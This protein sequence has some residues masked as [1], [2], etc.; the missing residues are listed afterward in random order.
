MSRNDRSFS[1]YLRLIE[2]GSEFLEKS[3]DGVP[4]AGT[5]LYNLVELDGLRPLDIGTTKQEVDELFDADK[6]RE[7]LEAV[8]EAEAGRPEK[9]SLWEQ[10]FPDLIERFC[11][12]LTAQTRIAC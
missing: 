9:L 2:L 12:D 3:L 11:P 5:A 6:Q 7:L 10:Y 1:R 4:G 8:A